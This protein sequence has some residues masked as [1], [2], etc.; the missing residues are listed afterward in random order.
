MPKLPI[1][2]KR[3]DM[4]EPC[5]PMSMDREHY[6]SLHMEWDDSYNLPDSGEMTVKFRKV[7]ETNSK[8]GGKSR[9]SVTLDII[10]IEDVKKGKAKA[11]D[12]E[13]EDYDEKEESSSDRLDRMAAEEEAD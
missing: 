5:S 6:P 2:L 10:S 13:D 11:S 12:D 9:Q 8:H 7:S 1:N 3:S 4:C